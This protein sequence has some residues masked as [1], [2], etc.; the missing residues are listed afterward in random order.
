MRLPEA[1]LNWLIRICPGRLKA[2]VN[3]RGRS[4]KGGSKGEGGAT[5]AAAVVQ[6]LHARSAG[7]V[8]HLH[9][10]VRAPRGHVRPVAREA[11]AGDDITVLWTTEDRREDR[12]VRAE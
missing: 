7:R 4:G 6:V 5:A 11:H 10:A 2:K 9:V 1:T 12:M 3:F 8:P